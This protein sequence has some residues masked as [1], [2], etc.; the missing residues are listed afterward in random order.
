MSEARSDRPRPYSRGAVGNYRLIFTNGA[1]FQL[2]TYNYPVIPF[3]R[4]DYLGVHLKD[5]WAVGS[6]LTLNLGVRYAHDRG[7]LPEQ[8]RV[9][10][11]FAEAGCFPKVSFKT[12]NP[13]VPRVHG[14]YT[15]TADGKTVLKGGWGRFAHMRQA[16]ELNSANRN[17]STSTTYRWSDRN[18]NRVYDP[19]E[20]N[21]SLTGPDF[22][23]VTNQGGILANGVPN[24]DEKEP[25]SD[26][27]SLSFERELIPDLAMRVT[28]IYA[29]NFNQYRMQ[30]NLRPYEVYSI[31][32]RN[33][34]PGPDGRLGSADDPGTVLTYYEYPAA[35]AS[36]RFQQ[37]M[38]INDPNANSAFRSIE[39]AASKRFD[40][41]W[42]LNA[43]YAATK[44]N[45]P[46]VDNIGSGTTLSTST[47]DPNAEIFASDNTWEWLGR[48]SA[49]YNLPKDVLVSINF[50]HRSGD[51]TARTVLFR[52]GQQILSLLLRVEPIGSSRLDNVNL[53]DMRLQKKFRFSQGHH[54][55][56]RVT[57][58]NILNAN[59][60]LGR[61]MQSGASFRRPTSVVQP[62]ILELSASYGF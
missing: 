13:V 9:A 49:A 44:K 38:L 41:R 7:Y 40:Q 33:A 60:V 30:N 22:I 34:D 36:V 39:V 45:I 25:M 35:Y 58:Y 12:W 2:E 54:A 57:V 47:F 15:L 20:V 21:L 27:F 55:D 17:L 18:G 31:P 5:T 14:V 23:A 24:S 62:R 29:R 4:V 1:P 10:A 53:A 48:V 43:S 19:G 59:P 46:F 52:G 11:D 50:E 61:Q 3:T 56:V 37:P 32:I 26:E 16:D 28:G 8:C 51:P 42:Q 6:R